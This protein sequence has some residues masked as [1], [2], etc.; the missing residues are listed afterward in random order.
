MTDPFESVVG[1]LD[2]EIAAHRRLVELAR[3]EQRA[4]VRGDVAEL[5][6]LVSE[7]EALVTQIRSMER[8]RTELLQLVSEREGLG[9]NCLTLVDLVQVSR[10]EVAERYAQQREALRAVLRELADVQK[11]NALLIQAHL[12]YVQTVVTL[13][14]RA[15]GGTTSLV[16][17]QLA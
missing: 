12:S 10:P 7:Q 16:L 17:D 9:S 14:A 11:A 15:A 6:Q 4:L 8:A 1:L 5:L 13:M 3:A 2:E